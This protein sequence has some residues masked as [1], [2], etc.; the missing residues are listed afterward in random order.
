M[1]LDINF[2]NCIARIAAATAAN[3]LPALRDAV[4]AAKN[5]G[6]TKEEINQII[7]AAREV[8]ERNNSYTEHLAA[9]LLREPGNH[10]AT[11][12]HQHTHGPNCGCHS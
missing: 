10:A 12:A 7:V 11:H 6:L 9:Q 2:V 3:A 5:L 4:N 1:S 8:R